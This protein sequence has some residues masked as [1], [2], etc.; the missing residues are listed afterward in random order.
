MIRE[1]ER[2]IKLDRGPFRRMSVRGHRTA[3]RL[4]GGRFGGRI[5][6]EAGDRPVLLLT[7]IGSRSGR[8]RTVPLVYLADGIDYIVVGANAGRPS[9]PAW[10]GNLAA[11]TEATVQVGR[12]RVHVR[13][14]RVDGDEA[15]RLWPRL[16]AMNKSY[17]EFRTLTERPLPVIRLVPVD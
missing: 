6:G 2:A 12:V 16:D 8:P 9:D 10:I 5:N 15:A 3:Y 17:A 7:S 1:V 14:E 11:H 13:A 4:S